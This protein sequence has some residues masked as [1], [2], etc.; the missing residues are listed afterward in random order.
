MGTSPLSNL[1]RHDRIRREVEQRSELIPSLPEVV[2][3][4]LKLLN[5]SK[6][7]ELEQ[8][9]HHLRN[10]AALVA[11]MLRVVNSPFYGLANPVT[12]IKDAVM[13]LG[14]RSLRSLVLAASTSN[15]LER[16]FSCYGHEPKGL[17]THSI[18]VASASRTLAV[19]I[20][21]DPD[22]QEEVFVAGLLHDI[23]KML[24]GPFLAEEGLVLDWGESDI[25]EEER[26]LLGMDHQEAGS[27][28]AE[29]WNLSPMVREVL[30]HH[31][32]GEPH[33]AF[34]EITALVRI[35]DSYSHA[36]GFGLRKPQSWDPET[37]RRDLEILGM[38]ENSWEDFA[39]ELAESMEQSVAAL[40][41]LGA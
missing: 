33:P 31:H 25:I 17:W 1:A 18:T 13:V 24:L 8:F 37:R 34:A 14:F 12:S 29:K 35:S 36:L 21:M 23:G 32:E 10:D 39:P 41:N 22:H 5:D 27:L 7:A 40:G 26:A 11:R 9:E 15:Y 30:L 28:I 4:I 2:T 38:D 20:R 6:G 19:A 3:Q 16:N